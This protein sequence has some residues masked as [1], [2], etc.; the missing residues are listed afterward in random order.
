MLRNNV[1]VRNF[2][3][4]RDGVNGYQSNKKVLDDD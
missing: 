1:P 4:K 3:F 2:R